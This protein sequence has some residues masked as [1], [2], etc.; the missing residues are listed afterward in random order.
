MNTKELEQAPRVERGESQDWL[1]RAVAAFQQ[2]DWPKA[3]EVAL[4]QMQSTPHRADA[5]F[6]AGLAALE[7]QQWKQ[8]LAYLHKAT[9]FD[10]NRAD[11]AAQFAKAL[12]IANMPGDALCVANKALSLSLSDPLAL[13]ALGVVYT[14]SNVHERAANVFRRAAMLAPENPILRFNFA[15]SLMYAGDVDAAQAELE[16]C[17]ALDPG[18]WRAHGML[19]KL[20]RQTP[21]SNH[22]DALQSLLAKNRSNSTA[23]IYL[24]MALGK[25]YEDLED[26]PRAFE[27]FTKGKSA[28]AATQANP[29]KGYKD[30]FEAITRAF[31]EQPR[32]TGFLANEPIFVV[33]MPRSGT[34]LVERIISSHPHVYSAGEMPNFGV[35]LKNASGSRT[36]SLLDLDTITKARYVHWRQLGERYLASTRPMTDGKPYFVDK[37]PHNFLYLG[38][39]IN[40]LPNAKIICLRRNPLDTCLGNFRELFALGSEF[41][42]Y[43]L[44][45]LDIGRYYIL[46]DRLMAHWKQVFPGRILEVSYETLV[47]AQ[48][49]S[50]RQLLEHCDLPWNNACL[51]FEQN[52]APVTTASSLQVRTPIYRNAMR[53]WKKYEPQLTELRALL[54]EEGI[55]CDQ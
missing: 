49:A 21:T 14:R 44:D 34:T 26:Y 17:L 36:A 11:Y 23:Q 7:L 5:C 42:D 22:V 2:K 3:Y 27:H 31:P 13:D 28:V 24:N 4:R 9:L 55:D 52:H 54:T 16:T 38:Y 50:T 19:S 8:A 30:V 46:F 12:S 39:I 15:T 25:E 47:G 1:S 10:A 40:A 41:H 53:R 45:L 35:V 51:H 18:Y 37:L 48:E 32:Q 43:S 33:G 6:I 29:I 20:R